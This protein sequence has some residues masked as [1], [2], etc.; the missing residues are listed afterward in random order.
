[1]I[2]AAA[3]RA[4]GERPEGT[5]TVRA[6][7]VRQLDWLLGAGLPL[8]GLVHV[9]MGSFL[10]MQ[11]YFGA[12]FAIGVGPVVGVGLIRNGAPLLTGFVLAGLMA[13]RATVELRTRRRVELDADPAWVADRDVA[14]GLLADDRPGP[15]DGRLLLPRLIAAIV[16]G[17]VLAAFG[18]AVGIG[19]RRPGRRRHPR[20]LERDAS[21]PRSPRSSGSAT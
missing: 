13:A 8:V 15:S 21:S 16:A 5:L 11:A 1:M 4:V 20:H 14:L 6:A 7:T 18:A 19:H 12:T 2:V 3:V 10:A 17:P 9:G